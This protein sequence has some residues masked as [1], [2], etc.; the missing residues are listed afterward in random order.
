[1]QAVDGLRTAEIRVYSINYVTLRACKIEKK[2][3][4]F[5][6]SFLFFSLYC[7]SV[8]PR[9]TFCIVYG[10][11]MSELWSDVSIIRCEATTYEIAVQQP[12]YFWNKNFYSF[13]NGFVMILTYYDA[14][15][16]LRIRGQTAYMDHCTNNQ[17]SV[18]QFN[19]PLWKR[20]RR[21]IRDDC[22][23]SLRKFF[24]FQ[25]D[26]DCYSS[27]I[28]KI[29]SIEFEIPKSNIGTWVIKI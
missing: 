26:C 29:A 13:R 2:S 14:P 12:R 6:I 5:F 9:R 8:Y 19:Y 22:N 21:M 27:I 16:C 3:R 10:D 28:L 20:I 7:S 25:P 18:R 17:V 23:S 24:F 4:V 11:N 1:M 15:V